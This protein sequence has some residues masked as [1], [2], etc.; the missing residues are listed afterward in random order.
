MVI[1]NLGSFFFSFSLIICIQLIYAWTYFLFFS[2]TF[3]FGPT[4]SQ[5]CFLEEK[6][7]SQHV[8]LAT[9]S[10]LPKAPALFH[11]LDIQPRGERR[12]TASSDTIFVQIYMDPPPGV[13]GVS[14]NQIFFSQIKL[15][16]FCA[17]ISSKRHKPQKPIKLKK[18]N[19]KK[20][21][22]SGEYF[23]SSSF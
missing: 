14:K 17:N 23:E 11:F 5:L 20:P 22:V 15:L 6:K 4:I 1:T 12:H 21:L 18:K 7:D 2:V 8:A 3:L 19:V 10:I 16:R 13:P 9:L